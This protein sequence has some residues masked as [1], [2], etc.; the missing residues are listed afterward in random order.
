V[1]ASGAAVRFEE[2]AAGLRA[3]REAGTPLPLAVF[4][5]IDRTRLALKGPTQTPFGGSYRIENALVQVLRE[6]R[7]VTRDL[8]GDAGTRAMT[9]AIVEK[10]KQH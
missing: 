10:L 1:L 7:H 6:K 2:V 4:D 5:S 9:D 8:G 3:E